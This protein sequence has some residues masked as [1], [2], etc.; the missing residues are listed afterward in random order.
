MASKETMKT[1]IVANLPEKQRDVLVAARKIFKSGIAVTTAGI[2][3]E[4]P[5]N[6]TSGS[7]SKII[8]TLR[9]KMMWPYSSEGAITDFYTKRK[10]LKYLDEEESE[11]KTYSDDSSETVDIV[12]LVT[13]SRNKKSFTGKTNGIHKE[14]SMIPRT[15]KPNQPE[16]KEIQS[17]TED[18]ANALEEINTI[19]EITEKFLQFSGKSQRRMW[20]YLKEILDE[21]LS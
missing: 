21:T 17:H 20:I 16:E 8:S 13:I 12:D 11:E 14:N 2:T 5:G 3:N 9:G 4:M 10:I 18:L 15:S 7:V 6:P 1:I 19:Q